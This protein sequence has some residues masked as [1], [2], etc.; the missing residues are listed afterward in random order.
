MQEFNDISEY[1]VQLDRKALYDVFGQAWLASQWGRL[2]PLDP[3]TD[4]SG[5]HGGARS[6]EVDSTA[7]AKEEYGVHGIKPHSDFSVRI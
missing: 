6:P 3:F 2:V 1:R 7:N 4:G 5:L